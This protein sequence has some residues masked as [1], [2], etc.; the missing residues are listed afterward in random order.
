MQHNQPLQSSNEESLSTVS[1]LNNHDELSALYPEAQKQWNGVIMS[2]EEREKKRDAELMA[3]TT[4]IQR[5]YLL[6]GLLAPLPFVVISIVAATAT[7]VIPNVKALGFFLLPLLVVFGGLLWV[8]WF[9]FRKVLYLF[10]NHAV[11]AGPFLVTLFTFLCFVTPIAFRVSVGVHHSAFLPAT[12]LVGGIDLVA[13]IIICFMLLRIWTTP[14]LVA[15]QRMLY[16]YSIGGVLLS[17]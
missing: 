10:Y 11:K 8:M 13:S 17:G 3:I 16:L 14:S 6:I 7:I 1:Q 2:A 15:R 5:Q 4:S 9:A 12:L